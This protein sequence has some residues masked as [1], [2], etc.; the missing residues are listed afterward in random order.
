MHGFVHLRLFFSPAKRQERLDFFSSF[1]IRI[2]IQDFEDGPI[3]L[4][5][6]EV[7]PW[8]PSDGMMARM[9]MVVIPVRTMKEKDRKSVDPRCVLT[10]VA[11]PARVANLTARQQ[12]DTRSAF[13][14]VYFVG[15]AACS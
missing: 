9:M 13:A 4:K 5:R 8:G 1:L 11:L 15:W 3:C 7:K 14:T 12:S 6:S 10:T 2:S